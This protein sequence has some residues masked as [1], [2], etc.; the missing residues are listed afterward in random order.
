[1]KRI[2]ERG[3]HGGGGERKIEKK[4]VCERTTDGMEE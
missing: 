3:M 2:L 4:R 1:M